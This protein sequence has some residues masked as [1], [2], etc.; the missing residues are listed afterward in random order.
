MAEAYHQL[1]QLMKK[2]GRDSVLRAAG[3]P[4]ADHIRW[5]TY[6]ALENQQPK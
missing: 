3:L 4:L 5:S 6:A 1:N 2:Y